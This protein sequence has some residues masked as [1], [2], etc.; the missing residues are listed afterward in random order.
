L[1]ISITPSVSSFRASLV[2]CTTISF[3]SL[4]S[5]S[6]SAKISSFVLMTFHWSIEVRWS[7]NALRI[8]FCCT[9]F[10]CF[11]LDYRLSSAM[12]LPSSSLTIWFTCLKNSI[13][14]ASSFSFRKELQVMLI[15]CKIRLVYAPRAFLGNA[16]HNVPSTKRKA[17]YIKRMLRFSKTW[18]CAE[19][20]KVFHGLYLL[21]TDKYTIKASNCKK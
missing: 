18:T 14:V 19:I 15:V 9:M 13:S 11:D 12:S 7:R 17:Y 16:G 20:S 1:G 6:F 4:I 10:F 5:L 2:S 21:V 8:F 3:N